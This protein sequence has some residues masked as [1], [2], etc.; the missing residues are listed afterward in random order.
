MREIL[1]GLFHWTT[2]H[3]PIRAR[4]SSYWVEPAA[5]VIDP[6]VPEEGIEAAW[7]DRPPPEQ[8]VLTS[9]LHHRD[10][11]AFM[12]AF[13]IPVRAARDAIE[14]LAGRLEIL[15][16]RDGEEIAPGVTGIEIGVLAADESALHI[17]GVG[18]GALALAD[19]IHH[20]GGALGFFSDD[21]LGAHPDRVK[22]GLKNRLRAQLAREFDALLFAHGD[23]LPHR[24]KRALR[25]FVTSPVGH[26]DFGQAL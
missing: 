15:P 16:F 23:P 5:I 22:E 18:E 7:A 24:G 3:E 4:V 20:Y 10:A 17:T 2:F 11:P 14:R 19:A 25:D 13:D 26:E 6:K 8:V 12:E 1:P 9:G 21:L